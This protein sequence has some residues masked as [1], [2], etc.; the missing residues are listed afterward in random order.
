MF[1]S[2]TCMEN[3]LRF[4]TDGRHFIVINTAAIASIAFVFAQYSEYFLE[5]SEVFKRSRRIQFHSN[6][7]FYW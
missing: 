4:C 2:V 1:I 7:T 5:H 3:S 6:A